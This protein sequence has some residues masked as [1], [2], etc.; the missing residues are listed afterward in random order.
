VRWASFDCA[1]FSAASTTPA[2]RSDESA[3][4]F[5]S[6]TARSAAEV[7]RSSAIFAVVIA[8]LDFRRLRIETRS[9]ATPK[10]QP[11]SGPHCTIGRCYLGV[12]YGPGPRHIAQVTDPD[13]SNAWVRKLGILDKVSGPREAASSANA[14]KRAGR[15]V[16][17]AG[18]SNFTVEHFVF[19]GLRA[20]A[21]GMHGGTVAALQ[22]D[23]PHAAFTLLRAYAENAAAILYLKDKPEQ[24]EQFWRDF[25][26]SGI[27]IGK[28]TNYA[29]SRMVQ[30]KAVYDQLSKYAH[31]HSQSIFASATAEG[32][33]G[34]RWQSMPAFKSER[35]LLT[36]CGW[37][38]EMAT[39]S[40]HL[41]L[42]FAQVQGRPISKA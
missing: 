18:V 32:K 6:S 2:V 4:R 24:L 34:F 21:Q 23:N 16:L 11:E 33:S 36:A 31:P 30:F 20:R 29:R 15:L 13:A 42:E 27:P 38:V 17:L 37:T 14:L 3:E 12:V 8:A 35:D 26:G 1:R 28:M 41:L 5:A 7:A 10:T 9:P 22:S 25:D 19:S 40:H 39:I